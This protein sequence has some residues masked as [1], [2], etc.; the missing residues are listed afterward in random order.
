MKKLII[1]CLLISFCNK[2]QTENI[3]KKTSSPYS[4]DTLLSNTASVL[5]L[6][7]KPAL[8]SP[9][10]ARINKCDQV[11]F[12]EETIE[13]AL[14][15]G[16]LFSFY[17]VEYN[18]T[19]I[20]FASSKYL[21][22]INNISFSYNKK[23]FNIVGTWPLYYDSPNAIFTFNDDNTFIRDIYDESGNHKDSDLSNGIYEYDG[24]CK[25]K[26]TFSNGKVIT[27]DVISISDSNKNEKT[28]LMLECFILEIGKSQ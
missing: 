28:T 10:I 2:E 19:K 17:K 16:E 1:L 5:N 21:K 13:K 12:L 3:A 14:V 11:S 9:I 25:L 18:F 6:R 24:C 4:K 22:K 15:N 7:E 8:D 20:G 23:P 27:F 26:A